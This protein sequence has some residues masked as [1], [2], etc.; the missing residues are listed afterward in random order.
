MIEKETVANLVALHTE[1]SGLFVVDIHVSPSNNIRIL[2]DSPKGVSLGECISLSKAIEGSLDRDQ[3]DFDLEV[4][5]PGLSEPLK[6][7][8]QY[9]KNIGR[10]VEVIAQDGQKHTGRLIRIT[11]NGFVIAEHIKIKGE[12]K[13]PEIKTMEREFD[14]NLIRSTKVVV[15]Y[16]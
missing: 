13:R 6:V 2:V 7:V 1:G 8:S 15:S 16:K 4:S 14:Y 5:S 11:G 12:K 10:D 3:Y 9:S